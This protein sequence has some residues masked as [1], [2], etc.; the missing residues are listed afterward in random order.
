MS[1]ASTGKMH[2]NIGVS[3]MLTNRQQGQESRERGWEGSKREE[4]TVGTAWGKRIC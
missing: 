3:Y 4:L 2:L 1:P